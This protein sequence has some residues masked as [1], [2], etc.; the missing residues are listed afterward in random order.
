MKNIFIGFA[1]M[2]GISTSFSQEITSKKK[3]GD[4][5]YFL[6]NY[7][8]AV[9]AYN[10]S[11]TLSVPARRRLAECHSK[12]GN[13]KDAEIGYS[14]LV[15][16]QSAVITEDYFCY[17]MVLK[18]ASRDE[19]YTLWMNKF[20]SVAPTDLRGKSYVANSP[21]YEKL[22]KDSKTHKVKSL[23]M[24][25]DSQDY[26]TSFF[27]DGI[28]FTSTK[29]PVK[30]VKRT[31]NWTGLPYSSIYQATVENGDLKNI[32]FLD[33]KLNSKMHD[34]PAS[35]NADGTMMAFTTNNRK[36]KSTDKIVELQIF[37][38]N[39]KNGKW[40]KPVAFKYNNVD[41][42]TGQPH[43][44]ADGKTMYFTSDM[45]G[46]FG[47]TDL[48]VTT[49]SGTNDWTTP[50]NLGDKI[51]TESD[52]MF[53][54]FEESNDLLF[55][56]SDGHFGLG[57]LDILNAYKMNDQFGIA[58]NIGSPFNT[59]ENDFAYIVNP[60]TK[61][62]YLSS[63]RFNGKGS[64]DIY[65]FSM[66]KDAILEKQVIGITMNT[67]G[68]FIGET[69]V[70]L[71]DETGKG[72]DSLFSDATGA[73]V[74]AI[75]NDK[76]FVLKGRKSQFSEGQ[77]KVSSFGLEGKIVADIIL[78]QKDIATVIV[79]E[80]IDAIVEDT[81]K[82]V[83]PKDVL[84]QN[85]AVGKT[86]I[87][88]PIYYVFDKVYITNEAAVELNQIVKIMNK[89]PNLEIELASYT[90]CRGSVTYNASLSQLRAKTCIEYIQK[91]ITTPQRIYGNGYGESK[92]ANACACE[93]SVISAC[94]EE[95]HRKNRRT[96]FII[97]K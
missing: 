57:G 23:E 96:E 10:S 1:L 9:A 37:T 36:D 73:F 47:G 7:D 85:E 30:L 80:V 94:S 42:S 81:T 61:A 3:K 21:D 48:Y 88:K 25:T 71:T 12:M 95:E 72:I 31:D 58:K 52:E 28:V 20:V 89:F 13:F 75:E 50:V 64:S 53:A 43:L 55:F 90:D 14:Y 29:E 15:N 16:D 45:P 26:G 83:D 51:N 8:E 5:H 11:K 63:N 59:Q 17:A 41:F 93:G 97:K 87:L 86:M 18:S 35:F 62:G 33:K 40:T 49:L 65:S 91:R 92:L 56:A 32:K 79:T 22:C 46:G 77:S 39:F 6:Y 34:G 44:S 19:D 67:Q 24:N 78:V 4:K 38:S 2:I 68:E 66:M 82:N 27:K 60:T 54:F 84:N 70:V 76:N 74:F 69:F